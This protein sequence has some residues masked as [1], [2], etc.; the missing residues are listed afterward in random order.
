MK[1]NN[2]KSIENILFNKRKTILDKDEFNDSFDKIYKIISQINNIYENIYYYFLH[3]HILINQ[4]VI[5]SEQIEKIFNI[6]FNIMKN[7][8]EEQNNYFR[9]EGKYFTHYS[10]CEAYSLMDLIAKNEKTPFNILYQLYAILEDL[11]MK[12]LI[13]AHKNFSMEKYI[14]KFVDID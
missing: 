13:I 7:R 12:N 8:I 5:T 9:E 2:I 10:N 14:K 11:E 3:L 1:N 6:S 4:P